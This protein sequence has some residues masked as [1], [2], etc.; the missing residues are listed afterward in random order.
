[1]ERTELSFLWPSFNFIAYICAKKCNI[2]ILQDVTANVGRESMFNGLKES[3]KLVPILEE[4]DESKLNFTP[5][6]VV[7]FHE[8]ICPGL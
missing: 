7:S 1:M 5:N 4:H 2:S 8:I 6:T 3:E